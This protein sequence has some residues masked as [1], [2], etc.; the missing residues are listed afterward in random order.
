MNMEERQK[1][2]PARTVAGPGWRWTESLAPPV[3]LDFILEEDVR[4]KPRIRVYWQGEGPFQVGLKDSGTGRWTYATT[5]SSEYAFSP[6]GREYRI[7]VRRYDLLESAFGSWSL[8]YRLTLD[9]SRSPGLSAEPV[10]FFPE[11]RQYPAPDSV[12]AE[13]KWIQWQ[14]TGPFQ[15][16]LRASKKKGWQN[17]LVTGNRLPVDTLTPFGESFRFRIRR[18]LPDKGCAGPWS[19]VYRVIV[20][21]NEIA[22]LVRPLPEI[23]RSHWRGPV[24]TPSGEILHLFVGGAPRTGTTLLQSILCADPRTNPLVSEAVIFRSLIE[25]YE[26]AVKNNALYPGMYFP[27]EE[28]LRRF[29]SEM[30]I[31]FSCSSAIITNA[32][33]RS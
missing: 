14:G 18:L 23:V 24:E 5:E 10:F 27:D 26:R 4:G 13:G 3:T 16:A 12:R 11:R 17:R 1:P 8:P 22:R 21:N 28:R 32:A 6:E 30:I 7:R 2:D 31:N 25:S 20:K 9:F 15:V 29:Y 33:R 19:G